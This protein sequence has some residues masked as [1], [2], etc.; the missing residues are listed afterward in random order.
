VDGV[1]GKERKIGTSFPEDDGI[2]EYC[3]AYVG[4][5]DQNAYSCRHCKVHRH[6]FPVFPW[7]I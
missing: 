6:S 5:W 1:E 2:L 7:A 3:S 4:G